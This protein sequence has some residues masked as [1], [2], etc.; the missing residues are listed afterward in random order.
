MPRKPSSR[1]VSSPKMVKVASKVL[2][3]KGSSKTSKSLAGS[4][5][6]QAKSK[7]K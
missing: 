7:R 2:R 1:R 6:S 5:L 4:V 3:N